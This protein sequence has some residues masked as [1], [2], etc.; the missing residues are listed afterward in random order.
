MR[1]TKNTKFNR[2]AASPSSGLKNK[3]EVIDIICASDRE[4]EK[5]FETNDKLAVPATKI[6]DKSSE[7]DISQ[8]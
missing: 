2:V 6:T 5:E 8:S 4:E 3:Q 1:Y 7:S